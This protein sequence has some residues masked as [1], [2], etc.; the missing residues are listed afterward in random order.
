MNNVRNLLIGFAAVLATV[1]GASAAHADRKMLVLI[2]ASG[3]MSTL[4]ADSQSRFDAAKARAL[5]QIGVQAG[6]GLDAVAVYTF[7]DTTATLQTA[8]GFVDPNIAIDTITALDL[9]TVGGGNTPLAGS[10]CDAVDALHAVTATERILEVASDGEENFTPS[11]HQCF[12]AFSSDPNPPYSAGSWE[13]LVYNKVAGAG[14]AVQIDL[15]DPGPVTGFAARLAAMTDPEGA[16]TARTRAA[17]AFSTMAVAA[18]TEGPPTLADFFT[19][20]ALVSGGRLTVIEDT[21]PSLPVTGDFTGDGCVD[22]RDA[23]AVARAFG[24]S[25]SP[26]GLPFDLNFDGSVG[27]TDYASVVSHFTPGGCGVPD[28]YV[29]RG[30]ITCGPGRPVVITGAAIESGQITINAF[31]ACQIT[32]KNSLVVSGQNA[33]NIVGAAVV[34]VDNSILVGQNAVISSRG[35]SLVIA[36]NSIFHGKRDV[37]GA[38]ALIDL[39]GNTFE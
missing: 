37:D 6:I 26:Q 31:P 33:I 11:D 19:Q 1:A 17:S 5:D 21:V 2:D 7:S 23:L 9:F 14:I 25:G 24:Q 36:R 29:A 13:N 3:S 35:A 10:M 8:G 39:G 38:F 16:L 32:I 12:G 22:R 28:P 18:A 15:F 20:I 4:R 34:S 27:F 30:P